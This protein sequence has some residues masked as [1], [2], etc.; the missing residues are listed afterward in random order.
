MVHSLCLLEI[1]FYAWRGSLGHDRMVVGFTTTCAITT[2]F[3]SSNPAHG[4]CTR[5]N[6]MRKSLSAT[7]GRSVFFS[8]YS[9]SSTN[10][11]DRHNI[12]EIQLKVALNTINLKPLCFD[13]VLLTLEAKS[14][15]WALMWTE[16]RT[17]ASPVVDTR[18][19]CTLSNGFFIPD[20]SFKLTVVK[21]NCFNLFKNYFFVVLY[22]MGSFYPSILWFWVL[23]K[24]VR[25]TSVLLGHGLVPDSCR[26]TERNGIS[27]NSDVTD[28]NIE[29]N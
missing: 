20:T 25:E 18:P 15:N 21:E 22:P 6:I 7:W 9:S 29:N 13:Y 24:G 14:I 4:R 1:I 11:T 19:G 28:D 23:I 5:Y 27:I 26:A 8:R 2:E 12:T 16:R 10:K 3:V 17:H